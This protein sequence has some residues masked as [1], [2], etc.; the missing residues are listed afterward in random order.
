MT[1]SSAL[2]WAAHGAAGL[3]LGFVVGLAALWATAWVPL[4]LLG[5]FT[6]VTAVFGGVAVLVGRTSVPLGLG[7][8]V[9]GVTSCVAL[10]WLTIQ[11]APD[12]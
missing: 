10:V 3:V 7:T 11:V 6:V 12:W 2:R 9:G 8:F 5:V 1:V 4:G